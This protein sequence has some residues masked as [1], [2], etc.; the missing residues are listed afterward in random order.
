MCVFVDISNEDGMWGTG[1]VYHCFVSCVFLPYLLARCCCAL[2]NLPVCRGIKAGHLVD[3]V[4]CE[5]LG[6]KELLEV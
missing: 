3:E 4:R 1:T 6:R 5:G 2:D